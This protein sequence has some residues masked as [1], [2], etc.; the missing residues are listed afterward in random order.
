MNRFPSSARKAPHQWFLCCWFACLRLLVW[1]LQP[2]GE[3]DL[4]FIQPCINK[5]IIKGYLKYVTFSKLTSNPLQF[6]E[7]GNI[8]KCGL[9][10]INQEHVCWRYVHLKSLLARIPTS[11][12][13]CFLLFYWIHVYGCD[14]KIYFSLTVYFSPPTRW[15]VFFPC[16]KCHLVLII[17]HNKY[18]LSGSLITK[19]I[20]RRKNNGYN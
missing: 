16:W 13:E 2:K 6:I 17:N 12:R 4:H 3:P 19:N 8:N 15:E 9:Y 5:N 11:I 1:L 18:I 10:S 7:L 20:F 14:Y